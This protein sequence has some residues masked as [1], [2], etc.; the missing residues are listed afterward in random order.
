MNFAESNDD[1]DVEIP[2]DQR[3]LKKISTTQKP[4]CISLLLFY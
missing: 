4:V 3:T 1:I 2:V